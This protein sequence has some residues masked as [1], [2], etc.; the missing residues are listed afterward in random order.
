MRLR[1]PR[2][3]LLVAAVSAA[4][5]TSGCG[6]DEKPPVRTYSMG[7]KITLGHITYVV[8]ETQWMTHLGEGA[9]SRVPQ[10]RFFLVRLSAANAANKDI[11]VPNFSIEDDTGK[12]YAELGGD[13]AQGVPQYIGYL[14]KV[15]P[16][17]AAQ[18]HAVFDAPPRHYKLKLTDEDSDK[19]AY[20]DIPL[21]FTSES[22]DV[23]Q[24]G[25]PSK[26]MPKPIPAKK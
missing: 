12:S 22:P 9:E 5:L 11:I 18:G 24:V 15:K 10:N 7:E 16:A 17:E 14:R 26:D 23:P 20:V 4:F 13:Q 21:S 19:F 3:L 2:Y 6:D 25:D 1:H 8:Y